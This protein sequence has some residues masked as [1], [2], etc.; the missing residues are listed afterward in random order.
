MN[1]EITIQ[2]LELINWINLDK[3]L[4]EFHNTVHLSINKLADN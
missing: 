1:I 2:S 4:T 3:Q